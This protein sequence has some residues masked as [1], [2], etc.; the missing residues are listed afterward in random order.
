[1]FCEPKKTRKWTKMTKGVNDDFSV[2]MIKRI[3]ETK[4]DKLGSELDV[5]ISMDEIGKWRL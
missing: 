4:D 5:I 2:D 3:V 1:M